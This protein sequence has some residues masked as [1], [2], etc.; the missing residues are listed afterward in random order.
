MSAHPRSMRF[1]PKG[2]LVKKSRESAF[3]VL[4]I[5]L[6]SCFAGCARTAP[7]RGDGDVLDLGALAKDF[8]EVREAVAIESI[9]SPRVAV[10]EFTVEY[11]SAAATGETR[12]LDLAASMKVELPGV[13]YEGF[14]GTLPAY[15]R[16]A[17]AIETVSE[18][19]AYGRLE[20]TGIEDAPLETSA[21]KEGVRYPVDGLLC[22]IGEQ[23]ETD[24]VIRDLLDEVEADYA[25][26][27]RLRVGVRAGRASI[28]KG[29]TVRVVARDG[30]GLLETKLAVVSPQSVTEEDPGSSV[31]AIDSRRFVRAV[32][33]L[34]R[35]CIGLALVRTGRA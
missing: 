14:V 18:A 13:L 4:V 3:S 5:S 12:E 21:V 35:P 23:S 2:I 33:Q 15:G 24:A 29:S 28:E 11:V 20:G 25:L 27:V 7:G 1:T 9:E 31:T 10:V 6:V 30:A 19:E 17:V 8:W 32:Q 26:Q 34:F 16:H 22:L